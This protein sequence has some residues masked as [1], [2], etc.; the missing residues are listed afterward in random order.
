MGI[1]A[2]TGGKVT[3]DKAVTAYMRKA[4]AGRRM[5]L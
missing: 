2:N 1:S 4:A 3:V 5:G